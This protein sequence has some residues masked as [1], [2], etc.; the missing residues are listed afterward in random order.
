MSESDWAKKATA[1][2]G[3]APATL[4]EIAGANRLMQSSGLGQLIENN[5]ISQGDLDKVEEGLKK[6]SS[7]ARK[8]AD[9]GLSRIERAKKLL[10]SVLDDVDPS[11][12]GFD[13]FAEKFSRMALG[14]VDE[15]YPEAMTSMMKKLKKLPSSGA[16]AFGAAVPLIGGLASAMIS[17][18]ASAAVPLLN[19]ASPVG[20]SGAQENQ[21]LQEIEER[22]ALQRYEASPA[23]AAAKQ[24]RS[25]LFP[26]KEAQA[27]LAR[28]RRLA[29]GLPVE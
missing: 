29:L 22:K 1:R 26:E 19:E 9:D 17:G 28:K 27:E 8:K 7:L 15:R 13:E 25:R 2:L 10:P 3:G 4:D 23:A 21:M 18:D 16:K 24:F 6:L 20:M 12:P 5:T 11:S 14:R